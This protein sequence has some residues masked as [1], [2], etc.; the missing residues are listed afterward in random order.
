MMQ[1][2]PAHT[3]K[4]DDFI[5]YKKGSKAFKQNHGWIGD[6][7]EITVGSIK[8]YYNPVKRPRPKDKPAELLED[9]GLAS[10]EVPTFDNTKAYA[11][12]GGIGGYFEGQVDG[13]GNGMSD[14]IPF[15]VEGND[16]DKA[17]LSR[18]EYVIPADAVAMLG[19][20]SSNGGAERLDGFIKQLREQSFGTQEQQQPI[21]RQ[22]GLS[23]L[24]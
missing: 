12:G 16:P 1:A 10:I 17:L 6:D 18:D 2:A 24:A 20:G 21:E 15:E 5:V 14:E 23:G 11:T 22:Q 13:R 7:G 9:S 19:N 8:R 4:P 3:N